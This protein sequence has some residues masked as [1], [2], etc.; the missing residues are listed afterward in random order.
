MA[1]IPFHVG[2]LVADL[3]AA[4][5][6]FSDVL[7]L[8]FHPIQVSTVETRGP[9]IDNVTTRMT[10]SLEG[11]MYI[12][13]IEGSDD[14]GPFSI[15]QGEG[16]HHLGVWTQTFAEYQARDAAACLPVV[17]TVHPGPGD[18]MVWLTDPRGL[19]GARI[20]YL[21]DRLRPPMESWLRGDSSGGTAN[22]SP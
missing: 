21:D 4:V 5:K 2:I 22:A 7:D 11:P 15:S 1:V 12:E 14:E 8:G 6:R 3:E 13:L 10:Y 17:T 19:Y 20:E 16:L 9:I 18:P